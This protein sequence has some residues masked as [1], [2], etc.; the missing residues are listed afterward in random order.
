MRAMDASSRSWAP[1]GSGEGVSPSR[2]A[3][4][5]TIERL[6][7]RREQLEKGGAAAVGH[8]ASQVNRERRCCDGVLAGA[9]QAP[10]A[11]REPPYAHRHAL[12]VLP[13]P[14]PQRGI[15]Q[16]QGLVQQR[17]SLLRARA[18]EAAQ[19]A[20]GDLGGRAEVGWGVGE[21]GWGG[22]WPAA[23]LPRPAHHPSAVTRCK[24]TSAYMHAWRVGR[25]APWWL[26]LLHPSTT[27]EAG[28]WMAEPTHAVVR[29]NSKSNQITLHP[30]T[31]LS[32]PRSSWP[33]RL[34]T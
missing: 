4:S 25:W 22:G 31:I 34:R 23:A 18:G 32:H 29:C 11:A 16:G 7:A 3:L 9:L 20:A 17:N 33:P 28:A 8:G 15:A 19:Q 1:S 10:C 30:P 21:G 5:A 26:R 24:R 2:T 14:A 13:A 27:H 6:R 12:H